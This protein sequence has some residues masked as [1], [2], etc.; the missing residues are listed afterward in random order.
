MNG[1]RIVRWSVRVVGVVLVVALVALLALRIYG[2]R[3]LAAAER[4]FAAAV[5]PVEGNPCASDRVPDEQNAAIYLQ[6]GI[7]ATIFLG[8]DVPL[9]GDL[10]TTRP[11][12]WSDS[13]RARLRRIVARNAPALE[14]LHRAVGLKRSNFGIADFAHKM[15]KPGPLPPVVVKAIRVQRLLYADAVLA[16]REHNLSGAISS[17]EVMSSMSA[18]WEREPLLIAHLVGIACEKMF[19]QVAADAVAVPSLDERSRAALEDHLV[20][21][22]LDQAWRQTLACEE[23]RSAWLAISAETPGAHPSLTQRLRTAVLGDY[24]NAQSVEARAYL[25]GAMQVPYGGDLGDPRR[26]KALS[27]TPVLAMVIPNLVNAL[28]RYQTV[29]SERRL[30]RLA[31]ALRRN[32]VQTGAYPTSVASFPEAGGRDPFTGGQ[33]SYTLRPDGSAQLA[34]PDGVKLWD[35]LNPNI[36][37]PGPFTWELPAPPRAAATRHAKQ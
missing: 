10:T 34:V 16:L 19:L 33:L 26:V 31:L 6:A 25:A 37:N 28:G 2:S 21:V 8:D 36:H 18:A 12:N 22:N 17:A 4:T 23:Y 30:A 7:D 24:L 13:Q 9:V 29:L 32:A 27:T 20:D 15:E 14:L 1:R 3:R 11:E 35:R 5:S